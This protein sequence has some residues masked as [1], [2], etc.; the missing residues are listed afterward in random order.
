MITLPIDDINDI[1]CNNISD[2]I[3]IIFKESYVGLKYGY[4][5]ARNR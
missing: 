3:E 5:L 2:E 1:L 4:N